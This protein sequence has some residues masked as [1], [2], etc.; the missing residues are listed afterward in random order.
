MR[1]VTSGR[2]RQLLMARVSGLAKDSDP[3]LTCGREKG[4]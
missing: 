1:I 3:D 2:L 4:G